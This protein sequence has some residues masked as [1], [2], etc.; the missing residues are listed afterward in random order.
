V[1]KKAPKKKAPKKKA[2][3]KKAPKMTLSQY[4]KSVQLEREE[5]KMLLKK[6]AKQRES[7]I[8][9]IILTGRRKDPEKQLESIKKTLEACVCVESNGSG[10]IVNHKGDIFVLTNQHVALEIGTIKFIMWID[11]EIGYA[12]TYWVDKE[13]D[14]GKMKIIEKPKGK[15]I[16][17]LSIHK[18]KISSRQ[19]VVQIHNPYHWYNDENT[20]S[21][22]ENQFHFPFTVETRSLKLKGKSKD[23]SHSTSTDSSVYF[24]SSGS[25]LI[26]RDNNGILGGVIGI[27]KQWDEETND[28]QGV[29]IDDTTL[30]VL[31]K[32]KF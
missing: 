31:P 1:K 24:G 22:K 20:G 23:F 30:K 2:P 16:S 18:G 11:G 32:L 26:Y 14:I 15:D 4:K 3:K 12:Q 29:L 19:L 13:N 21:R 8:E 6:S 5:M 10:S 25:P 9:E 7:Q 27:H 17:S 28:F